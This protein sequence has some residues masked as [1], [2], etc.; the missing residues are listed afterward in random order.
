MEFTS[1]NYMQHR[2]P[3]IYISYPPSVSA[4]GFQGTPILAHEALARMIIV[5]SMEKQ[6][7]C[8]QDAFTSFILTNPTVSVSCYFLVCFSNPTDQFLL[9]GLLA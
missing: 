1:G 9:S 5:N 7:K 2:K 4:V 3:Q 8:K 6:H